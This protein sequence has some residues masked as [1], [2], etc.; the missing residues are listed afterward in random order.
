MTKEV[1]LYVVFRAELK[2]SPETRVG[3]VD[4]ESQ[5]KIFGRGEET[6]EHTNEREVIR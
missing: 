4:R 6:L 3:D 2:L 1:A 5:K